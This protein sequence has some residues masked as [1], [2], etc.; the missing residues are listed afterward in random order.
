MF[1][2]KSW[3]SALAGIPFALASFTVW[4]SPIGGLIDTDR[5]GYSGTISRYDTRSDAENG[6]NPID[7]ISIGDRDLSL[8]I[9]DN[10]QVA[11]NFNMMMGSWWYTTDDQGR[12]GWGNTRGNTGVGFLQLYDNDSSTDS[13]LSM[14]F[15][16]FDGTY[17]TEFEMD[18]EGSDA[19][20]S[21]YARLSAYDNVNDGGVWHSYSLNLTATGL[22][23][24]EIAP[25]VIESTVQPTGVTGSIAGLFEITENETSPDRLGFYSVDLG[26]SMTN[27][28]WSNRDSLKTQDNDGNVIDDEFSPSVFRTVSEVPEPTML[29]L[30]GIAGLMASFTYRRR[31]STTN[32]ITV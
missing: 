5:F 28:A 18:L 7:T 26:L 31:K 19:G 14:M 32:N 24:E 13:S 12:S 11:P 3:Y 27:W 16:A 30:L 6:V 21:D 8:Y 2:Y 17:Y 10:D 25:G 29:S 1:E 23:G 20:S 4:S 22:Q 15:D 9:A